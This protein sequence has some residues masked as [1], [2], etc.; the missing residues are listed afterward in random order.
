MTKEH[1]QMMDMVR[2]AMEI[3]ESRGNYAA[4]VRLLFDATVDVMQL[5]VNGK[6]YT[7]RA[8]EE[9]ALRRLDAALAAIVA[10]PTAP[11]GVLPGTQGTRTGDRHKPGA[12]ISHRLPVERREQIR[13]AVITCGYGTVQH[14]LETCVYRLLTEAEKRKSPAGAGTSNKG[15][16]KNHTI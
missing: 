12:R 11:E 7:L 5:E 15:S 13:E 16:M 10:V 9:K 8:G 4:S 2:S 3:A 1:E 14:W 6:V